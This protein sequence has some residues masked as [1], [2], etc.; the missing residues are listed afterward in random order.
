VAQISDE[1]VHDLARMKT[2]TQNL[3]GPDND[4]FDLFLNNYDKNDAL[5]IYRS[6][7]DIRPDAQDAYSLGYS[8]IEL[9]NRYEDPNLAPAIVW[10][11]ENTPSTFCRYRTVLWLDRYHKLSDA[12]RFECKYDAEDSVREFVQSIPKILSTSDCSA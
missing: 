3:L 7:V 5:L 4:V 10:T 2:E 11:Y 9:A 6:L 1:Q 12:Y 8:L